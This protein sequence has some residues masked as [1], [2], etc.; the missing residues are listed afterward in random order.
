MIPDEFLN[1]TEKSYI[2]MNTNEHAVSLIRTLC[3]FSVYFI[4]HSLVFRKYL[5]NDKCSRK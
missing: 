2:F 4:L 5:F 3:Q 1:N